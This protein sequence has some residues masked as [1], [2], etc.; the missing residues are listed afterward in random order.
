MRKKKKLRQKVSGFSPRIWNEVLWVGAGGAHA[1]TLKRLSWSSGV[2]SGWSIVL[3]LR[4]SGRKY[5]NNLKF[6]DGNKVLLPPANVRLAVFSIAETPQWGVL[7]SFPSTETRQRPPP[8]PRP[9][10]TQPPPLSPAVSPTNVSLSLCSSTH[11]VKDHF[12]QGIWF[13][14]EDSNNDYGYFKALPPSAPWRRALLCARCG[15][16]PGWRLRFKQGQALIINSRNSLRGRDMTGIASFPFT[17]RLSTDWRLFYG[18]LMCNPLLS[19]GLYDGNFS[20]NFCS[21]DFS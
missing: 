21:S 2:K 18:L 16:P 1:Q 4:V 7:A 12:L 3:C 20:R 6:L 15:G 19:D 5:E 11:T 8:S 10:P 17:S 14:N 13:F 9:P